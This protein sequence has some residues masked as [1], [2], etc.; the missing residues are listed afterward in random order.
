[1]NRRFRL[2]NWWPQNAL[3]SGIPGFFA[4]SQIDPTLRKSSTYTNK[5]IFTLIQD[6]WLRENAANSALSST[7]FCR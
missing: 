5:P 4:S 3:R 6:K 2:P 7:Y 1:M